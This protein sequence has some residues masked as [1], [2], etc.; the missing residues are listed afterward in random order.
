MKLNHDEFAALLARTLDIEESEASG[1]LQAWVDAVASE[2]DEKGSC[3]IAGLGT[4]RKEV[5]G[6]MD[7]QPDDVLSL[8]V[9]HKF[10]G[11]SP[12]EISPSKSA[13]EEPSEEAPGLEPE[14]TGDEPEDVADPFGIADQPPV[15]QLHDS[16]MDAD[17]EEEPSGEPGFGAGADDDRKRDPEAT[18]SDEDQDPVEEHESG[19]E[20]A[21]TGLEDERMPGYV[22]G[23]ETEPEEEPEAHKQFSLPKISLSQRVKPSGGAAKHRR[24]DRRE[25]LVWLVPVAAI[26]VAALL[27]YFHFDGQRLDRRNLGDRPVVQEQVPV[28][29]PDERKEDE[30]PVQE[31]VP[32]PD[33]VDEVASPPDRDRVPVPVEDVGEAPADEL[34]RDTALPYGL[35][36]PEDEVLIG[37]YTIV[38][39]SLRNERKSEIEKQRLENQG[40]KAT[41]WAAVLP[42]GNT[43][44]RVGIGQFSTVSDAERAVA[45]LPEPFRSNNF[46]IRIR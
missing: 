22:Y 25:I 20:E 45:E 23:S 8:E 43:T 21:E 4:F 13:P 35:R 40:F 33:P 10:A 28:P 38:V 6:S 34:I 1:K 30:R 39:H 16:E 27:L 14:S 24:R 37:A 15:D 41:R 26:L 7:F 46:I 2:T 3:H 5:D 36:G 18:E 31:F 19:P 12:I 17:T 9:N 44:Y 32:A 29:V 42:N 11:L